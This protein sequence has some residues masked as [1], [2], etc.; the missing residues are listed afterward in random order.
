MQIERQ[1]KRARLDSDDFSGTGWVET[2]P[3]LGISNSLPLQNISVSSVM[4]DTRTTTET[5]GK[6]S[7]HQRK[8]I[9]KLDFSF[10]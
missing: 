10:N 4:S 6:M 3:L 2:G 8:K 9:L 5:L 7:F 1:S